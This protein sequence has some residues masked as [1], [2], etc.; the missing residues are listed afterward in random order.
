MPFTDAQLRT[1]SGKLPEKH[2]RTR[3]QRG[4]TLS[5]I[6][7]WHAI[8]EANRIFGFDGWD[9]ETVSSECLWQDL[10]SSP[11]SCAYAVRVRIRVRAGDTV[12]IRDGSGVGHGI[13]PTVGEAHES[14]LKEAETDATKRALTTFG[15]LF[16]LA[17]YDKA[18]NG[19]RKS[20]KPTGGAPW[21]PWAVLGPQGE[22]LKKHE[23]PEDFCSGLKD[24]IAIAATPKDLESLWSHNGCAL[25]YL[26]SH[27]RNLK[28]EKG[29]HY[30]DILE[31][32]YRQRRSELETPPPAGNGDWSAIDKSELALATPKRVRDEAHLRYVASLPCLICA[33]TPS[34]AHHLRFV[35]PRSMGSKVSD[36]WTVPLCGMHHQALHNVG[37]EQRWWGDHGIDPKP[38]AEKLWRRSRGEA[39]Q[40][41]QPTSEAVS[42]GEA[43][44]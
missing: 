29:V 23:A 3:E 33:R 24:A 41:A 43:N 22:L 15:N 21:V 17:L 5:Y 38:E 1:L 35:Q 6:E 34:Q 12:V 36:E 8:D 32:L 40:Q 28:T 2:V 19:V 20:P 16:G 4:V 44:S 14:A 11:K 9:R 30:A 31:Q 13:G 7:G 27:F 26:R 39:L 42:A 18:Q 25:V 37:D 10:R